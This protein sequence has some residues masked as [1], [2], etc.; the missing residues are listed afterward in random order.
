MATKRK[1]SLEMV[2]SKKKTQSHG[3]PSVRNLP[4]KQ[5][6][7]PVDV[8]PE[9]ATNFKNTTLAFAFDIETHDIIRE[10]ASAWIKGQHG[11]PARVS[12]NTIESLRIIQIGWA[13]GEL[14][15]DAPATFSRYV[16]PESFM[17]TTDATAKHHLKQAEL[18]AQGEKLDSI[19]KEFVAS[20]QQW[21]ARGAKLVAH[22]I[23]FDGGVIAAE[24]RRKG[25]FDLLAFWHEAVHNGICTMDPTLG[26]WIREISGSVDAQGRVLGGP[27]GLKDAVRLMVPESTDLRRQHHA[28]DKD[29]EMT[30]LLCKATAAICQTTA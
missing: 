5:D 24:L 28:A 16:K 30:W 18:E 19:L 25:H 20:A 27:L 26:M 15:S 11:F 9:V 17:V 6:H 3:V 1:F 8:P 23:E 4:D 2:A 21:C 14:Q 13:V 29:A 12:K 22:Q 10:N 7:V